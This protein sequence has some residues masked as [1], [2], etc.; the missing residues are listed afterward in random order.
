MPSGEASVA[1]A[2]A[3]A[4]AAIDVSPRRPVPARRQRGGTA[5]VPDPAPASIF[6]SWLGQMRR[7]FSPVFYS[8]DAAT[9]RLEAGLAALPPTCAGAAPLLLLGNHQLYGF[10]GPLIIEEMLRER[11]V[12]LTALVYPP[13]LDETSPLAPFPYPLPGTAST[14]ARFGAVPASGRAL[15]RALSK[16]E[17]A[18][19]F[20]GGGREVFKRKGEDY[21][22]FW[23]ESP[24]V[25][26]L[27]ARLNATLLPF[28]G[29]GGDDSFDILADTDEL[30]EAPLVGPFFK[31]RVELLP[32][33]VDGDK[34]VPPFGVIKPERYYF[35]FGAPI[36]T[37][38]LA[39]DDDEAVARVYA[40]LKAQVLGGIGQLKQLRARDPYSDF[41]QRT[42]FEVLNGAQAPAPPPE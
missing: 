11:G 2:T 3:G 4:G 39:P 1:D 26:R 18:L 12:A 8:T 32:S 22:L 5:S 21:Q 35:A 6:E 30:L 24:D 13:L 14:F 27:A 37:D 7:L 23:P 41:A 38:D 15:F 31:E 17:P 9:G 34:F 36:A 16:G 33:L 42:A 25:V 40:Q 20:P 10:D 29:V 19:L 28:S